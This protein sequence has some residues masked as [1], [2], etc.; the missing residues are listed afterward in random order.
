METIARFL[1]DVKS[2]AR[3]LARAK[4]L[5]IAVILTLALGI[6]ANAAI[7]T[8]LR[9]VLL[10]PLVNRDESRLIYVRQVSNGGNANFSVPEILDISSRMKSLTSWGDF[11]VI[12]FTMVG[13]G[14]PRTVR[15]GVVGGSYFQTMGL[16]PAAGRLLDVHDD[17]AKAAGAVVLTYRFWAAAFNRDPAVIGKTVRFGGG[18]G[19]TTATVVGVLEPSVPYPQETEVIANIVCSPHHLSATMVT[20]RI[21]RMTDLFARL[22]QG[23]E[24]NT[25]RAELESVYGAMKREHPEAYPT[26]ADFHVTAMPLRDELVSNARTMLLVLMAASLLVFI[27]ACANVANLILAR[28]VR[29]QS[30]LAIRSALGATNM[31]LRRVLLAESL[32][33]CTAGATAGLF[34]AG[35]LV[36]VLAKYAGRYSVR[37]LD[38]TLDAGALWVAAGL[39]LLAAVLLAFVPRL[40]S[41]SRSQ[42]LELAAANSRTT[43]TNRKLKAFAVVQIAASFVL[44]TAASAALATLLAMQAVRSRFETQHVLAVN[45]P[46]MRGNMTPEQFAELNRQALQDVRALPGVR[47][48]AFS[49]TVPWRDNNF[50][51]EFAPDGKPREANEKPRRAGMQGISPGFFDTLGLPL[52]EGRD[53]TDAD[54]KGPDVAIVSETLARQFFPNGRAVD[55]IITW[56]DPIFQFASGG[57]PKPERIIGVVP[58]IDNGNLAAQ[59]TITVYRPVSRAGRLLV[60]VQGDPYTLVQPISGILRKLPDQPVE[61]VSTL[62]DIRAEVISPTRLNMIVAS[63]FAGVALLI[64][65]VGVGGVLMFLVSARMREFGIRLALGSQPR[66]L[67]L[68]VIGEGVA[69]ALGGLVLGLLSGYAL[70]RVGATYVAELKVPGW[71][72]LGG[73]ALVLLLSAATAAAI[74]A[75]RAARVDVMQV[76]R[77]E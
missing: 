62:A 8:L 74:P 72:A 75:M 36:D 53:F 42:A 40:P 58:D 6:G 59:P 3:S 68:G 22:P 43:G 50:S 45:T 67:L 52:L 7:F 18:G 26:G 35:P 21:H 73:S 77:N 57:A 33:L 16:K 39:A 32:V 30:E 37:A 5:S 49:S 9:G 48:A 61:G 69:L 28:S 54:A 34:I 38:L 55:H 76:L 63:V 29:R 71:P 65:I 1:H 47:H 51:F 2:A 70:A 24:L 41:A 60:D 64:A 10:R 31:D 56:T 15:A 14:E 23:V 17:G 27:I 13:L 20:G 44:V 4:T 46:Q 25:A 19:E 12:G 66:G 11:S